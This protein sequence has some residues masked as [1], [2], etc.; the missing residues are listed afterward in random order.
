[1]TKY[2][3]ALITIIIMI[4]LTLAD[5]HMPIVTLKFPISKSMTIKVSIYDNS[6]GFSKMVI[7]NIKS[8]IE[9]FKGV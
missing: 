1:M 7:E 5:S 3:L 2:T 9:C 6:Q 8:M 4:L